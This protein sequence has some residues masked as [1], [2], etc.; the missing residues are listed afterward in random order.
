MV[1]LEQM[2]SSNARIPE[3]LPPG[4]VAVFVGGT[5]GIGEATMKQLAKYAVQPRIYFIG[6]SERA[7]ARIMDE[8]VAINP[9]GEYHFL[10]ADLS[11]LQNV[12]QVCCEIKSRESL[13]NLIFLTSGT[14]VTGKETCERLYYPTAVTYYARIRLIVNLLPL[15]Q[16]APALRRVVSVFGGT[17]EGP[18]TVGDLQG[19]SLALP[20]RSASPKGR[21]GKDDNSSS[22]NSNNNNKSHLLQLRAHTSSMMTLA[23]ESLALE[24]P[25][26]SFVH[27]SPG[28]VRTHLGREVRAASAVGLVQVV[29]NKVVGPM[30]AVGPDEAGER[31]LYLATSGRFPPAR[32]GGRARYSGAGGGSGSGGNGTGTA[33]VELREGDGVAVAR[34][35]DARV[36]SGVYSVDSEGEPQGVKAGETMR[37]L[38]EADLVRRLWLHTVGEFIRVTGTEFV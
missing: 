1:T 13:I 3:C 20:P 21:H 27:S 32:C 26:V 28:C 17:K 7:A 24:A 30:V 10:Q 16:K 8:L 33:G 18:V 5:S 4:V 9:A 14:L 2:R 22:S 25:D 36:G 31:Q 29:L 15:L 12:D 38:R 35:T 19:R 23:L 11:L 34:G 6:R 37:R